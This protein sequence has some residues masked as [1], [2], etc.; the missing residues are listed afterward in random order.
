MKKLVGLF[1]MF[2]VAAGVQAQQY[3]AKPIRIIVAFAPGG[4]S[5]VI[6]RPIAQKLSED[7]KVPVIVE[8]RTGANGTIGTTYAARSEP[9]GYTLLCVPSSIAVNVSLYKARPIDPLTDL[10]PI[11]LL[12]LTPNM[13][14]VNS[15][16]PVRSV[17]ELIEAAKERQGKLNYATSGRGATNHMAMELF[18]SITRANMQHVPYTGGG[19]ALAGFLGGQVHV[20]FNP[21]SALLGLHRAGRV[22]VIGVA[23]PQRLPSA[24]DI[25]TLAESGL[26]GFESSVWF[27]LFAPKGTPKAITTALNAAVNRVLANPDLLQKFR[28]MDESPL[29][30]TP[31]ELGARLRA[32]ILTWAKV[33]KESGLQP[34]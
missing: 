11:S 13:L 3:P 17:K 27:G 8:N 21:P 1:L 5:D 12:T 25:P 14:A 22:Q 29:G 32:D 19:P 24:P 20:M 7:L 34:E 18:N 23:S 15:T 9:D 33:V 2:V 16:L 28:S 4:T 31:E 6:M 30:G 10:E 26:P